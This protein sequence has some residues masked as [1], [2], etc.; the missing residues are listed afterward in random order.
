MVVSD[1]QIFHVS[2][3]KIKKDDNTLRA[4]MI[5]N[6]DIIVEVGSLIE[7]RPYVVGFAAET[8]DAKSVLRINVLINI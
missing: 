8:K 5:K 6:P 2:I 7:H 1:Y 3:D 4:I